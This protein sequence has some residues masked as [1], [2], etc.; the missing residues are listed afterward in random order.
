MMDVSFP[1]LL[2]VTL[3]KEGKYDIRNSFFKIS[4]FHGTYRDWGKTPV[5]RFMF[6]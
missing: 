3:L 1:V 2:R 6:F 4:H 5:W